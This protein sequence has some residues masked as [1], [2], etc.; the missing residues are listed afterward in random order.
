MR[1]LKRTPF[2]KFLRRTTNTKMMSSINI[3]R[4]NQFLKQKWNV[5]KISN[6]CFR[7]ARLS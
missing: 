6:S 7:K 4:G 2:E 5:S 3:Y 1:C